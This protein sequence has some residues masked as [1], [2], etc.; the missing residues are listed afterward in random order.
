MINKEHT[1]KH[2]ENS[3]TQTMSKCEEFCQNEAHV[4]FF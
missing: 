1:S 2:P 3:T 4:A